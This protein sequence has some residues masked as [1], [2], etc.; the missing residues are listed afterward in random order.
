MPFGVFGSR[1]F[2]EIIIIS[3]ILVIYISTRDKE[4]EA[5]EKRAKRIDSWFDKHGLLKA[6]R[7]TYKFIKTALYIVLFLMIAVPIGFFVYI[8]IF[9]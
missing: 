1:S 3:V 4:K 8:A 5:V 7:N 9:Q 6:Y 2:I